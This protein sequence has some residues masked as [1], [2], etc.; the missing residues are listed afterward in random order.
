M[1]RET[2]YSVYKRLNCR[3]ESADH[4]HRPEK[5]RKTFNTKG[6]LKA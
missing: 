1:D 3:Y 5:N 6:N 2:R 4:T